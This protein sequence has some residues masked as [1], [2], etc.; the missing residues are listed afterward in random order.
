MKGTSRKVSSQTNPTC[1]SDSDTSSDVFLLVLSFPELHVDRIVHST[2]AAWK[3]SFRSARC[4]G[5]HP[6]GPLKTSLLQEQLT[7]MTFSKFLENAYY[8]KNT[9]RF[10][11]FVVWVNFIQVLSYV[12]AF[13]SLTRTQMHF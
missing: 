13:L 3:A 10:Q 7:P 4:F 2:T 11:K 9:C 6:H 8:I 12:S 5:V 1:H